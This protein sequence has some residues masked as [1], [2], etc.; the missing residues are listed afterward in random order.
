MVQ[1][2]SKILKPVTLMQHVRSH[3]NSTHNVTMLLSVV[4]DANMGKDMINILGITKPQERPI[5]YVDLGE[6]AEEL[7]KSTSRTYGRSFFGN[8]SSTDKHT[9]RVI[10]EQKHGKS[11]NIH[12]GG[13]RKVEGEDSQ[14]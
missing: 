1:V 13:E 8:Y 2:H 4:P 5:D 9:G 6:S 3:P 11:F 10:G 14:F 12:A 7:S